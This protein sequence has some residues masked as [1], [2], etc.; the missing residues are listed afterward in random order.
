MQQKEKAGG[1]LTNEEIEKEISRRNSG[2]ENSHT[3]RGSQDT[4]EQ[5]I[6]ELGTEVQKRDGL[7]PKEEESRQG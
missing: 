2:D 1:E 5:T 3:Y 6:R 4:G 7:P